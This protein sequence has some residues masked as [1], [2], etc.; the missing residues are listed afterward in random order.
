[1]GPA[2]AGTTL[3]AAAIF[4]TSKLRS[5]GAVLADLHFFRPCRLGVSAGRGEHRLDNEVD[6][7][8]E[9]LVGRKRR[10]PR[11]AAVH[12]PGEAVGFFRHP[13]GALVVGPGGDE[14]RREGLGARR[15]GDGELAL[16][17]DS[18]RTRLAGSLV[19]RPSS[20]SSQ[21]RV[22]FG[23]GSA[24]KAR[25]GVASATIIS[26]ARICVIFPRT[27]SL[28]SGRLCALVNFD[29]PFLRQVRSGGK[30]VNSRRSWPGHAWP[31]RLHRVHRLWKTLPAKTGTHI[32]NTAT[33]RIG[34]PVPS[35]HFI[36]RPMKVNWPWP[37]NASRLHRLSM[38]VMSRS[39]HAL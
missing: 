31:R 10:R 21:V 34:E 23:L 37:S 17:G 9:I 30:A 35:R 24:A 28:G 20:M 27:C 19:R 2:F 26:T 6:A 11:R 22:A 14:A 5:I 39:R 29:V 8:D 13:F 18:R 38:W 12:F 1:M 4:P 15:A 3:S 25:P 36:G 32:S 7:A 16:D 33:A